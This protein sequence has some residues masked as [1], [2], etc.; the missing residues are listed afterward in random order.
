MNSV[1]DGDRIQS[2]SR[3]ELICLFNFK[4]S[5]AEKK[6]KEDILKVID[7]FTD[8]SSDMMYLWNNAGWDDEKDHSRKLDKIREWDKKLP[9]LLS[10]VNLTEEEYFEKCG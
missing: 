9:G 1:Q 5:Q 7:V 6:R 8:F 10:L 4:L 2:L 3:E